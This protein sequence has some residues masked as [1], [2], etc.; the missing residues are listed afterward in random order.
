MD[1]NQFT[2][3]IETEAT[4]ELKAFLDSFW[5]PLYAVVEV[6]TGIQVA[7]AKRDPETKKLTYAW[8][9][10]EQ[11]QAQLKMRDIL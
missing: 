5:E 7:T 9:S 10:E 3:T 6:E 2:V 11:Y 8:I 4:T 1:D